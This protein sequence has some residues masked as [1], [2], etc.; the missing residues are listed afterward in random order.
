MAELTGELIRQRLDFIPTEVMANPLF[1]SHNTSFE[2]YESR[3]GRFTL[4]RDNDDSYFTNLSNGAWKLH[5]D[6]SD[7]QTIANC[8]VE[9]VEQVRILMAVYGNY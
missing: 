7:M 4:T 5:I 8:D 2:Q 3:C 1:K 6:N 9:S